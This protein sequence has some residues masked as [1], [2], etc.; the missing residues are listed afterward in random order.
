MLVSKIMNQIL[1]AD[2]FNFALERA[3]LTEFLL[4]A[5]TLIRMNANQRI[6]KN[7]TLEKTALKSFFVIFHA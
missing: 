2:F 4:I 1:S 6:L 5:L 7:G 3:Q